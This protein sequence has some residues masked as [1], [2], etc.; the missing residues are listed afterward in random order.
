M[1]EGETSR[2]QKVDFK[3]TKVQF[4]LEFGEFSASQLP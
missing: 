4:F 1:M 3:S 2:M